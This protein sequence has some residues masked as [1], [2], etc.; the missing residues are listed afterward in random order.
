FVALTEFMEKDKYIELLATCDVAI[1]NNNRQQALGN[2]WILINLGKK[3]FIRDD[4]PMWPY[5]KNLGVNIFDISKIQNLTFEQ[6]VA[7]DL[8]KIN[9]NYAIA[10]RRDGSHAIQQWSIVFNDH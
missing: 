6:F 1:L 5:F 2:I 9:Q 4:T 3:I 8:K 10:D 7:Y